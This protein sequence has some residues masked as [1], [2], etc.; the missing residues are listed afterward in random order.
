LCMRAYV[1]VCVCVCV[2]HLHR[3]SDALA[4]PGLIDQRTPH[5]RVHGTSE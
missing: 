1:C 4:E 3:R 2:K 5:V